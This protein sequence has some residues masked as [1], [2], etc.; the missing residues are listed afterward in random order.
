MTVLYARVAAWAR[1][2]GDASHVIAATEI[3]ALQKF[4]E[5]YSFIVLN[6]ANDRG[7]TGDNQG[8]AEL[9]VQRRAKF[10]C[11]EW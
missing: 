3:V 1:R 8:K 9:V 7:N 10:E 5:I 2:K 6:R 4:T 11:H